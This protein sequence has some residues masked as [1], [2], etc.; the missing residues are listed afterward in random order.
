MSLFERLG[1]HLRKYRC[2]GWIH[3]MSGDLFIEARN[4]CHGCIGLHR[5][6]KGCRLD[7]ER[8]SEVKELIKGHVLPPSFDVGD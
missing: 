6:E 7:A 8:A 2:E 3:T 1:H 5:R 4:P